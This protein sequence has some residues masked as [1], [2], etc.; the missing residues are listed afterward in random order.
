[1]SKNGLLIDY[2][3]CTGCHSCEMACKAEHKLKQGEWGIQVFQIGPREIA[4]DKWE[5]SFLPFPTERCDLCEERVHIGKLP[6][7]VHHC[8]ALVMEYGPI[9][10]LAKKMNREKMVLFTPR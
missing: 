1:M 5:Y 10:E 6:S 8:Q 3:F 9:E 7:C 4:P 2:D